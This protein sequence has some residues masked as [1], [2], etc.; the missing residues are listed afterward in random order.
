MSSLGG[1]CRLGN[2]SRSRRT[3]SMVSSTDSVVCEIQMRRSGS[4]TSRVADVVGRVDDLDVV[5]RLAVRALDLLVALVADQQDVVVLGREP[6]GL[7]V[8]L[9][10]QRAGRVD[11]LQRPRRRR[12]VHRR[13]DTVRGEHDARALGH[14]VGLVHEDRAAR[15]QRLDHVLVVDDLLAHVDRGAVVLERLLDGDDRPVD[16]GAVAARRGQE[17]ALA[18]GG[19]RGG[20]RASLVRRRRTARGP[21]GRR[22]PRDVHRTRT[23]ARG[24]DAPRVGR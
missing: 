1:S 7:L 13:G 6:H 10:D 14:L 23:P 4:R 17:H 15:R 8:H 9:G 19:R 5:G 2:R 11:R 3:V 16:A 24:V 18:G 12:R 20:H 21:C 22:S